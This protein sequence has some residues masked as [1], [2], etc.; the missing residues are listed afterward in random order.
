LKKCHLGGRHEPGVIYNIKM[1]LDFIKDGT[2]VR[3]AEQY[4]RDFVA[5]RAL[6][7]GKVEEW[8]DLCGRRTKAGWCRCDDLHDWSAV[9][10]S[11]A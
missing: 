1:I 2:P 8:E 9:S 7:L 3:T 11:C 10:S 4:A 5:V 6:E